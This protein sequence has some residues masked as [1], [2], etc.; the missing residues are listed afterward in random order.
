MS[1]N[2]WRPVPVGFRP[3][4]TGGALGYYLVDKG[5]RRFYLRPDGPAWQQN[6]LSDRLEPGFWIHLLILQIGTSSCRSFG[7]LSARI[8]ESRGLLRSQVSASEGHIHLNSTQGFKRE[9]DSQAQLQKPVSP[10]REPFRLP[11]RNRNSGPVGTA[12]IIGA[13]TL[14]GLMYLLRQCAK[15]SLAVTI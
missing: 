13:Q 12:R 5:Q 10:R 6:S 15:R 1:A 4:L 14:R 3:F 11:R 7:D 8:A 2:L 9:I